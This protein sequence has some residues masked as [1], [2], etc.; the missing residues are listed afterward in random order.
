MYQTLVLKIAG[1]H[2]IDFL[3]ERSSYICRH[4]AKH[5]S[6]ERLLDMRFDEWIVRAPARFYVTS[7]R[8]CT[9]VYSSAG[10]C[11]KFGK[12]FVPP[13]LILIYLNLLI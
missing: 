2:D 13:T 1:V 9:D 8:Q 6:P 5:A 4:M 7:I 12:T 11:A 3:T 10:A